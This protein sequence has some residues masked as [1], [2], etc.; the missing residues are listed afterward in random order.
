M[1]AAFSTHLDRYT[2]TLSSLSSADGF[3][4]LHLYTYNHVM[5]G[6]SAVLSQAHLDQLHELPVILP[7]ALKHLATSTPHVPQHFLD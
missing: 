4:P 5:D 7:H 1:L 6:F 2:S 3:S